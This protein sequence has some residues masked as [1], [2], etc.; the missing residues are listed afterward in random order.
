MYVRKRFTLKMRLNLLEILI[1]I[2]FMSKFS[3]SIQL[4]CHFDLQ[5]FSAIPKSEEVSI[6]IDGNADIYRC[7]GSIWSNIVRR[8]EKVDVINGTHLSDFDN[9]RLEWLTISDCVI[10]YLPTGIDQ[11][12]VNVMFLNLTNV[13]LLELNSDDLRQFPNL[14]SLFV[15]KN[16]LKILTGELFRHNPQ[17]VEVNFSENLLRFVDYQ[18]FDGS[19]V[20]DGNFDGNKCL[21]AITKSKVRSCLYIQIA[22]TEDYVYFRICSSTARFL[23]K[24]TVNLTAILVKLIMELNFSALTRPK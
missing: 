1:K 9:T 19:N 18:L 13:E 15:I 21:S 12:F 4:F 10:N 2:I 6:N 20:E 5:K 3:I 24:F 23:M 7:L 16:K 11:H 17:L 8:N 14:I 22:E